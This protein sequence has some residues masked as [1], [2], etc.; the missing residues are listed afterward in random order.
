MGLTV[1]HQKAKKCNR[2]PSKKVIFY[3]QPSKMQIEINRQRVSSQ[4]ILPG[5]WLLKKLQTGKTTSHVLKNTLS[6]HYNTRSTSF[7]LK[8]SRNFIIKRPREAPYRS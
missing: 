5:F 6:S 8:I 1:S 2:Q 4:L 7:Y 3:R